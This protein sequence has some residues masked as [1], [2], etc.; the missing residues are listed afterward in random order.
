MVMPTEMNVI[1]SH[2]SGS[3]LIASGVRKQFFLYAQSTTCITVLYFSFKSFSDI[4]SI[5]HCRNQHMRLDGP[6]GL[7]RYRKCCNFNDFIAKF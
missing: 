6:F 5:G 2:A 4:E 3:K 1:K 7:T